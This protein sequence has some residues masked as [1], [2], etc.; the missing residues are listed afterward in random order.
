MELKCQISFSKHLNNN[1]VYT[2]FKKISSDP[3]IQTDEF[4]AG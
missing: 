1:S 2:P 4:E 3:I